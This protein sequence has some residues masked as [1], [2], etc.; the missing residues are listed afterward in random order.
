[1]GN[2]DTIIEGVSDFSGQLAEAFSKNGFSL[3][4]VMELCPS[5]GVKSNPG[6]RL[7]TVVENA[8]LKIGKFVD[9]EADFYNTNFKTNTKSLFN[10]SDTIKTLFPTK[11]E[12]PIRLMLCGS[13]GEGVQSAAEFLLKAGITSGLNGTK[14]GSYPVTVGVGFSAA[15]IIL[16]SDEILYTGSP[17][18]DVICITSTDG[19]VYAQKTLANMTEGVVYIDS[20]LKVP[21]IKATVISFPFRERG[22]AKSASIYSV[23]Y[24]LK[25]TNMISTEA[26]LAV[27][28]ESRISK[29]FDLEKMFLA[30]NEPVDGSLIGNKKI[31]T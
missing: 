7:K 12:K 9:K 1:M 16:S 20:S 17:K 2:E 13:A 3:V 5:Y 31:T 30:L 29:K 22:G 23:F 26:L 19:L 4:E 10:E 14:K 24:L 28:N 27:F 21:E 25:L 11:L 8:G 6:M 18:P 15:E